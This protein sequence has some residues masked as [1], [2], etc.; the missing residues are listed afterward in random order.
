MAARSPQELALRQ[1]L[2]AATL[3]AQGRTSEAI[4]RARSAV[5]LL[6]ESTWPLGALSSYCEA[7]G[8]YDDAIAAS[9][10][11]ATLAG[12]G[13]AAWDERVG[14]L[15]ELKAAS[16]DRRGQEELLRGR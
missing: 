10:R 13:R 6:P 15:R 9:E 4:E 14:K 3:H 7:A 11:A 16:V 1:L 2:V 8:R 12:E 5:G